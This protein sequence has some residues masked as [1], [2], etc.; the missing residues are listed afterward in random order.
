MIVIQILLIIAF[1]YVTY[2]LLS[3]R[4]TSRVNAWK[5]IILVFFVVLA[6]TVVLHP[7]LSNRI[8]N[9]VGVGRGADLLLYILT[10]A[11][12]FQGLSNYVKSKDEQKQ[13]VKLARKVAI[14]E[15]INN[16]HNSEK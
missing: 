9:L 14:I 8:A 2:V 13:F 5:K 1:L 11:F 4:G 12:I 6:I 3:D 15:A 7:E 16:P 10:V